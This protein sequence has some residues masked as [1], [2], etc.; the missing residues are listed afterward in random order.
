[1]RHRLFTALA[2]PPDLNP[3]IFDLRSKIT[4]NLDWENPQKLHLTLNFLGDISDEQLPNLRS[5][6]TKALS[7]FSNFKFHFGFLQTIYRRHEGSYLCLT[8]DQEFQDLLNLQE[9]LKDSV[10]HLGVPVADRFWPHL[11][12]ARVPKAD[13]VTTKTWLDQIDSLDLKVRFTWPV[14]SI[15]LYESSNDRSGT[16][17]SRITAYHLV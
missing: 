13:P 17:F 14:K 9:A 12:I 7:P 3:K 16:H 2:F 10:Y 1:M 4:S 6:L 15:F 11:T 5:T 8:P